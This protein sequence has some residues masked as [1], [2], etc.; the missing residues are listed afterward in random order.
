MNLPGF[1]AEASLYAT[2]AQYR[3]AFRFGHITGRVTPAV[4]VFGDIF[5]FGYC[6]TRCMWNCCG[7]GGCGLEGWLF[8]IGACW[9]VCPDWYP[10][11]SPIARA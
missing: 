8:C 6:W 3:A 5:R 11:P 7:H 9:E 2:S 1:T 10:T 4:P